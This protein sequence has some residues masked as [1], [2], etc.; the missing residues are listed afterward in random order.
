MTGKISTFRLRSVGSL[1]VICFAASL[2]F[3]GDADCSGSDNEKEC[4]CLLCV[5]L[6][7]HGASSP[8]SSSSN[9][10]DCS[11][12]C[13][14][15]TIIGSIFS[16]AYYPIAHDNTFAVISSVPLAPN[17]IVYRPPATA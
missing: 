7:H 15:P 3:C 11:C 4:T 9:N 5:L 2:L 12:V 8:G 16:F 1:L 10:A 6:H 17:R 13:H 14:V